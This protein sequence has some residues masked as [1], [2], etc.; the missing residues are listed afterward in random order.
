[1]LDYIEIFVGFIGALGIFFLG[2]GVLAVARKR[3]SAG[4]PGEEIE[5]KLSKL[6]ETCRQKTD[7]LRHVLLSKEELK[8]FEK[9]RKKEEKEKK[10]REKE[11]KSGASLPQ[12]EKKGRVFVLDFDGDLHASQ[13]KGFRV[14]ISALIPLLDQT[15]DEVILRL[16]SPGGVVHGYGL[17]ASQV[18]RL[19]Q[20]VQS[21]TICVDKVAASGGYMMACLG[22]RIVAAPFAIVGSIGVLA[23]VPN[24]H[25]LLKKHEVDYLEMT[26]GKYKRT[27]T[28]FGEVTD[29][30]KE[31][32]QEQIE[33][34]HTLFKEHVKRERPALDLDAVGTG[35]YWHAA[36][37]VQLGLV[38]ELATS[39][40]VIQKALERAD[41]YLLTY[42]EKES[43]K[44][45]L[46]SK[47]FQVFSRLFVSWPERGQSK[48][49]ALGSHA[50][51]PLFPDEPGRPA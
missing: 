9:M 47:L 37:G 10:Q 49:W 6:N 11:K 24:L 14:A 45:K 25:R 40:E 39:D 5:L 46:S 32:F 51:P 26:A 38:D 17:A 19:K 42:R 7:S 4:A 1:M 15:R 23:G 50:S 13:T 41:V 2:L 27:L 12:Q 16:E 36:R 28:P 48:V 8:T 21:L 3:K 43:M 22:S 31:K 35:E 34:I 33:D 44:D 30:K 20:V 18:L 29:E